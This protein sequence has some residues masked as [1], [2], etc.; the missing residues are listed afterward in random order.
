MSQANDML[1]WLSSRGPGCLSEPYSLSRVS[2][3]Q[4]QPP[5]PLDPSMV[6]YAVGGMALFAVLAGVF[7]LVGRSGWAWICVAG[8][9]WGVP[10]L[11]VMLRH[12]A[13]RRRRDA[14]TH[15]SSSLSS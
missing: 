5:A 9:L 2:D 4:R 6:P 12:D 8:V 1:Q 14:E 3:L 7:A 11:L 10:G 15:N 13:N